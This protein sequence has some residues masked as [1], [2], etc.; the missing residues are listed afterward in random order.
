MDNT[1]ERKVVLEELEAGD[2]KATHRVPE[3]EVPLEQ[4]QME[5]KIM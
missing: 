1:L 2:E 3:D 4:R 5:A